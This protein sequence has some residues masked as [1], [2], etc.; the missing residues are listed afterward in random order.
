LAAI[1]IYKPPD[2]RVVL[3]AYEG[4]NIPIEYAKKEA[5]HKRQF[6]EE[7]KSRG[8]GKVRPSTSQFEHAANSLSGSE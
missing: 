6:I 8:G 7:W 4:K 3:K 2:V 5:E 1:G